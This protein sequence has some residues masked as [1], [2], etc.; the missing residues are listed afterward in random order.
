MRSIV[1][2]LMLLASPVWAHDNP[3]DWIGQERRT[4]AA[5]QLCCG[6]GDCFPFDPKQMKVTPQGMAFPDEPDNIIPFSKFAPSVDGFVWRCRWGGETKCVFA[7][8][9]GV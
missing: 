5:G 3:T 6:K 1:F 4:N 7:P 9:G 2:G 8:I